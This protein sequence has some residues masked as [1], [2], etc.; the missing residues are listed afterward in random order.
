MS[1]GARL[2]L[3]VATMALAGC[4]PDDRGAYLCQHSPGTV[5]VRFAPEYLPAA[6]NIRDA[7]FAP[8]G[9]RFYFTRVDDER[10]TIMEM[11]H[12][13][14]SWSEARVAP[15]SG[16]HDD[17][18]PCISPDGLRFFFASRRPSPGKPDMTDD[19]DIWTMDRQGEGWSA[20]RLVGSPVSTSC[21]EYAPSI[22][23]DGTLYFGRNDEAMTRGDIH[24]SSSR[25]GVFHEVEK[26][27][28]SVNLP[29]SSFNAFVA[30]DE[31]YL[32]FS[33]YV[34]ENERWQSDLFISFR[35]D[36]GA[37][38]DARRL[39]DEINSTGNDHTPFVSRDGRYLFFASTREAPDS[40]AD[41]N[42]LYWV[43]ASF[44]DAMR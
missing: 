35:E 39:S 34:Q 43:D 13:D 1:A 17:F 38:T 36:D 41:M 24:S 26:L 7:A 16:K 29:A 22:T 12:Q 20:P 15:F 31:S 23:R 44:I 5:P 30:P 3:V 42:G 33:V 28:P 10:F 32:L 8:D 25:D 19:A 21:M 18:E 2:Q 14:G 9:E 6:Q 37:W 11:R 4:M 27:P 40:A